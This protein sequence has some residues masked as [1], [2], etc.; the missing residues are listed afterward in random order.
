MKGI[1][2]TKFLEMVEA[3][4]GDMMADAIA[5]ASDGPTMG[6]YTSVGT[7]DMA[8]LVRM[9]T[10]LS[11]TTATPIPD[12]LKAFGAFLIGY[13]KN[14]H[15]VYFER[16]GDLFTMLASIETH[17]H[18]DVRKLYDETQLPTF[19]C[20]RAPATR[21]GDETLILVYRSQR[22]LADLCH[23]MIEAA[24]RHYGE[25]IELERSDDTPHQTTFI[26]HRARMATKPVSDIKTQ[27]AA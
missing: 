21:P 23:G 9:L 24:A 2:F 5:D 14:A 4:H 19:E 26:I 7:Y 15:A 8:E 16:A 18:V 1:I 22:G 13:F 10:R 27:S 6:A 17:I 3:E 11:E 20:A 25:H 12:L